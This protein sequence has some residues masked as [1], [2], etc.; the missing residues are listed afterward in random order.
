MRQCARLKAKFRVGFLQKLARLATLGVANLFRQMPRRKSLKN[1]DL[2]RRKIG[3]AD[4]E[5]GQKLVNLSLNQ[6]SSLGL[7]F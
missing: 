2:Q 7:V 4:C 6:S 1:N 3:S 5:M